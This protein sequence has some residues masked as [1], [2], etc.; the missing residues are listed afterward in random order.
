[1]SLTQIAQHLEAQT[2]HHDILNILQSI[3][4][5]VSDPSSTSSWFQFPVVLIP[6]APAIHP[7]LSN[8]HHHLHLQQSLSTSPYFFS[9][10]HLIRDLFSILPTNHYLTRILKI[11]LCY[12]M[13]LS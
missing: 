6:S 12:L 1:M 7:S 4:I 13:S 10:D 3:F 11:N 5:A 2:G 8:L 9:K